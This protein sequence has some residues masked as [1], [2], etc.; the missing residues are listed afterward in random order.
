MNTNITDK[1]SFNCKELLNI[2]EASQFLR[3]KK[4]TLYHYT[5][6][7]KITFCKIG[8]LV[9]FR[10]EDLNEFISNNTKCTVIIDEDAFKASGRTRTLESRLKNPKRLKAI[11]LL[12]ENAKK[13]NIEIAK[14]VGMSEG[15]I[16]K[17]R[18]YMVA[19][20]L[21]TCF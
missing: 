10:M 17:I 1:L 6:K 8:K 4:S 7:K 2:D 20:N 16:R 15:A 9:R 5:M 19:N 12:M 3:I 14:S 18:K 21:F 13:T 11:N